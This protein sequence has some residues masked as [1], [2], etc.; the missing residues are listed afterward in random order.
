MSDTLFKEF[1]TTDFAAWAKAVEK[2]LK[3]KPIASLSSFTADGIEIHPLYTANDPETLFASQPTK[4]RPGWVLVEEILVDDAEVANKKALEILNAGANGLLFYVCDDVDVAVL[5]REILMQHISIHFVV[6]GDGEKVLAN[7]LGF[8]NQQ[9]LAPQ[10]LRGSIN[11]D[12]IESASRTGF[13]RQDAKADIA[14]L[15]KIFKAA[16][17]GIKTLCINNSLFANAGATPAQQLGIVLAHA[18]EYATHLGSHILASTWIN[19]AIGGQYFEEIAKFRAM[20]RLWQF[21][22]EQ[23]KI[24]HQHTHIYAETGM[25]NK[26][27][28]DPWVN[29]LRTT[30]EAMSAILGGADE[31]M[32]R[33]FDAMYR[34]PETLGSR[35]ARNQQLV[36]AYESYFGAVVDPA[37]GSY[38]V[39]N[40]TENMADKGWL[41][42]KEIERNGGMLA[43]LESGWLQAEIAKAAAIEQAHF[44]SGKMVLLGTNQYPNKAEK[45]KTFVTQPAFAAPIPAGATVVPVLAKRLS[46][47]IEKERLAAE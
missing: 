12:P 36:L 31:V 34:T 8:A 2:E 18:N 30:T 22:A 4:G 11:T 38:F 17:S 42:F 10:Q 32:L 37:A 29:M 14:D 7:W 43:A 40:L 47:A 19:M 46:E 24:D 16:P 45:M 3:G 23:M 26:T 9:G 13:W 6:S 41:F 20:R 27:I 21:Y 25:R 28:F 44:D 39:E 5:L 1:L 15:N 33:S 35:V